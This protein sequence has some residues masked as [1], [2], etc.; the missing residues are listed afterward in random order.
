MELLQDSE[1]GAAVAG[2]EPPAAPEGRAALTERLRQ[3]NLRLEHV[4]VEHPQDEARHSVQ[5]PL[6][7]LRLRIPPNCMQPVKRT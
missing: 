7:E 5:L 4:R 3:G 1:A 6:E 2:R